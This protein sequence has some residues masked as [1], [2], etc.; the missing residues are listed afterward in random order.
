MVSS[1][2]KHRQ[3]S[4]DPYALEIAKAVQDAVRPNRVIL[5]GSRAAGDHRQDSDVDLMVITRDVNKHAATDKARRAA[6]DYMHRKEHIL[7]ISILPMDHQTF[8]QC[9]QA[10]QH[11]AA[12][13]VNHGVDMSGE[14]LEY[15]YNDQPDHQVHYPTHW[16]ATRQLLQDCQTWSKEL[17][18]MDDTDHWNKKMIGFAPGVTST[19]A[20]ETSTPRDRDTSAAMASRSSGRP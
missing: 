12:Q 2:I 17:Q 19:S 14:P 8:H 13:A 11:I 7:E 16:P 9:R 6:L 10:A 18:E 1:R 4:A 15:Q 5:F 20:G 3:A